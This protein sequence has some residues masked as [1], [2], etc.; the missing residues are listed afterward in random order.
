[1]NQKGKYLGIILVIIIIVLLLVATTVGS[2]NNSKNQ[3][4]EEASENVDKILS[5]AQQES[6]KV[7][8]EEKK[9]FPQIN[10]D[11]YLEYYSGE[12]MK[13][14]LLARPTCTYCQIAEPIIQKIAKDYNLNIDYLNTDEFSEDDQQRLMNSDEFF[15]E[16]YGTP[17]LLIVGQ[18]KIIDKVDGLT[19]TAHYI[20]FFKKYEFIK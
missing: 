8:D 10:M 3:T 13:I 17:V 9:E 20:D 7:T 19:D 14:V 15:K 6:Q 16:G 12:E 1:M 18:N 2:N 11:T 5:N 4:P